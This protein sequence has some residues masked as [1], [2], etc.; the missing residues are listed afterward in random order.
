[1]E[2][3]HPAITDLLRRVRVGNGQRRL[4][5]AALRIHGLRDR[6]KRV[7]PASRVRFSTP[8]PTPPET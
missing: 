2:K 4:T 3:E 7:E 5:E 8:V 1:M 6:I